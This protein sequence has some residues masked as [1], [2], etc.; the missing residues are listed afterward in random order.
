MDTVLGR[1]RSTSRGRRTDDEDEKVE[2][3]S[4]EGKVGRSS[5]QES[6]QKEVKTA[7]TMKLLRGDPAWVLEGGSRGG[8]KVKKKNREGSGGGTGG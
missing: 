7:C 3:R 6:S 2:G 1:R 4:R 8:N 5:K